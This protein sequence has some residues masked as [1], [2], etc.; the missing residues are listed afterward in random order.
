MKEFKKKKL[1][2]ESSGRPKRSKDEFQR[3]K[4]MGRRPKREKSRRKGKKHKK[5]GLL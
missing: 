1:D 4:A 2:I 5:R 3:P